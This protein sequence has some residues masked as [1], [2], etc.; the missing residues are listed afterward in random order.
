MLADFDTRRA[1]LLAVLR[2]VDPGRAGEAPPAPWRGVDEA[3]PIHHRYQL[4]HFV[5]EAARHAGHA[6]LLRE[7][8][9]GVLVPTLELTRAGLAANDFFTPYRPAAGTITD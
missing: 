6:D 5:A 1:E 3:R 9:D 7:E 8:L 2:R 4:M